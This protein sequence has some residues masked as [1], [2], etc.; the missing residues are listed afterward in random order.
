MKFAE[1]KGPVGALALAGVAVN[2]SGTASAAACGTGNATSSSAGNNGNATGTGAVSAA[3]SR[4]EDKRKTVVVAH[5]VDLG[6]DL[7]DIDEFRAKN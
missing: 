6:L 5:T 3:P 1:Q 2:G 7:G 4:R